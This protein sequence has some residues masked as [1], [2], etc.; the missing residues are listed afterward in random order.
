[1]PVGFA[2]RV[3]GNNIGVEIQS[4]DRTVNHSALCDANHFPSQRDFVGFRHAERG[5]VLEMLAKKI[6]VERSGIE[7]SL[8]RLAFDLDCLDYA[9]HRLAPVVILPPAWRDVRV[10]DLANKRNERIMRNR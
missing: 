5:D 9:A 7:Q 3:Y 6:S 8:H 10:M 4:L 2:E 1:M